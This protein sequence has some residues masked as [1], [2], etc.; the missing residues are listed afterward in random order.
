[1]FNLI[2]I[3]VAVL[4]LGVLILVHEIGHFT[5]GRLL[6]FDIYEFGMG[7]GPKLWSKKRKGIEY[8]VR[9]IPFGGFVAFDNEENLDK[10]E[11]SFNKKPVW[12]RIIVIL[13]GPLMNIITAYLIV[14]M[15][16][17]FVG[18]STYDTVPVVGQVTQAGP[19]DDAGIL[20]GDEFIIINGQ[21]VDSNLSILLEELHKNEGEIIPVTVDRDNQTIDLE[22]QPRFDRDTQSYKI[23]I[24]LDSVKVDTVRY[25]FFQ[26]LGLGMKETGNMIKKL[27]VFF[28]RMIQTG[29]GANDVS[30]PVGAVAV[31]SDIART[32]DFSTILWMAGFISINLGVFNLL[33]IPPFDGSKFLI[34]LVEG[35]RRKQLK[36]KHE[37][38]IQMVGVG[39]VIVLAVIL[40]YRDILRIVTGG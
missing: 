27:I 38:A 33:P 8:S 7:F 24:I 12:K 26:S 14:V 2:S 34:Y 13:A 20:A 10:G 35:I 3:V 21:F 6:G 22:I 39:L 40:T 15:V 36:L 5:A 17:S 16:L 37:T 28:G 29:E 31:M 25:G 23:G 18:I 19:A 30:G 32:Q 1:M 9:A 11:L 4:I